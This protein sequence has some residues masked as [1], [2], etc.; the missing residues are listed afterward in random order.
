MV[1]L[2]VI[3]THFVLLLACMQYYGIE[4]SNN[5]MGHRSF[6]TTGYYSDVATCND[7]M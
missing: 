1:T 6:S 7:I 2:G 4:Y 3:C 5:F